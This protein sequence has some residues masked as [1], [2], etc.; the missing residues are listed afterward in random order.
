MSKP[1][2]LDSI[3]DNALSSEEASLDRMDD[4]GD[5]EYEDDSIE[6]QQEET[7][8]DEEEFG[9]EDES[10]YEDE[11]SEE[12]PE[13]EEESTEELEPES[14]D[15][16]DTE[17]VPKRTII[18][19]GKEIEID[20]EE[21]LVKLAET[22][23]KTK[24]KY[25]KSKEDIAILEGI[26]EQG[27]SEQDLYLL[28]EAKKGNPK[29]LA[30]LLKDSEVSLDDIEDVDPED[31]VPNEYKAD[32]N[33][34]EVKSILSDIEK[35]KNYDTFEGLIKQDFDSESKRKLFENPDALKYVADMVDTGI[36]DKIS[37]QYTKNKL[38]GA[39][40]LDALVSAYDAYREEY[41]STQKKQISKKKKASDDKAIKRK[42]ASVGTKGR[43]P[44][45]T[46]VKSVEEMTDEEFEAY[47]KNVT[48]Q[49]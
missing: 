4:I 27:L 17:V 45:S 5:S 3:D 20:S 38:L 40:S 16:P 36:F 28:V 31:Y 8:E 18:V 15:E 44:A 48:E 2:K 43:K 25:D 41:Q 1:I 46:K 12:E 37:G 6:Y 24:S 19:D 35:S 21:E 49:F 14:D 33:V 42:K 26:R 39:N 11:E 32:Q 22:G 29:A 13:K 47:Y 30:K 10:E 7:T 23:L 9:T 34:I